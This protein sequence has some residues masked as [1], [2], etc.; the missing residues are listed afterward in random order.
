MRK[1]AN[2]HLPMACG[3]IALGFW[4][5]QITGAETW[6]EAIFL[7]VGILVLGGFLLLAA[8][9]IAVELAR[10]TWQSWRIAR[11]SIANAKAAGRAP[12]RSQVAA[13]LRIFR[14]EFFS[15][16][17]WVE[18]RNG[19]RFYHVPWREKAMLA[20]EIEEDEREE[21]QILSWEDKADWS[22]NAYMKGA[23]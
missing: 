8:V 14:G 1:K 7:T 11:Q 2:S 3:G 15:S 16:Y 4:H 22:G 10:A 23:R 13:F 12:Q 21:R 9:E 17:D 18:L 5:E 6:L 19:G 20:R